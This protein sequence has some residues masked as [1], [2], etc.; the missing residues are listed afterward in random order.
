MDKLGT[1]GI[2]LDDTLNNLVNMWLV[3]YNK[4]YNDSLTISDIKTWEITNHIKSECGEK[5]FDILRTPEWFYNLSIQP[6]TY[7]VTKWLNKYFDLYIVTATAHLPETCYDKSRWVQKFLPHI[8]IENII[9]CNNKSLIDLDYLIDDRDT[10]IKEFKN[11]GL[12][13]DKP[14]NQQVQESNRIYRVNGWLDVYTYFRQI[15]NKK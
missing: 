12:I 7:E 11:T 1:I 5:L 8:P 4:I 10:N 2:D 13:F 14:W 3:Q 6:Y 15:I 9:F